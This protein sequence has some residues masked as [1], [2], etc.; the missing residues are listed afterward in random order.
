MGK[1][2][3]PNLALTTRL[4]SAMLTKL[5]SDLLEMKSQEE[6]HDKIVFDT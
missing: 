2:Y 1:I 6:K 3:K 4:I 5:N